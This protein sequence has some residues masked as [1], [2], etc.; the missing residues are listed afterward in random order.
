MIMVPEVMLG[1]QVF[2]HTENTLNEKKKK[3]HTKH[4]QIITPPEHK[5]EEVIN[6]R[7]EEVSAIAHS[8]QTA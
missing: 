6:Y 4:V 1:K 2:S 3:S 7:G 5:S 8:V